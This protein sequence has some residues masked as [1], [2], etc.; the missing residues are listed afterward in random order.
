MKVRL[1]VDRLRL[2][3]FVSELDRPWLGTPFLFQGFLIEEMQD[4][5]QLREVSRYVF[6]D[7]LQSSQAREVQEAI[8]NAMGNVSS[9]SRVQKISVEFEEWKGAAR[10]RATLKKLSQTAQRSNESIAKVL[11]DVRLGNSL[12][13][14]ANR[15]AVAELVTTVQQNPKTAQWMTLLQN[16]DEAIAAHCTNVSV[17]ATGFAK[18]LGWPETM[19]LIIGEGAMLHD[20]GMSRVPRFILDKPGPLSRREFELIKMHGR[21]ASDLLKSS[22]LYDPKVIEIVRWHHE[23]LDGS[24]YPDTLRGQQVPDYV[25]VVGIA[26]VYESMTADKPYEQALPPSVALTRLHKRAGK[27]FASQLIEA[28]IRNIGIYPLASLV[29]LNNGLLGIV[30]SSQEENRLK[31][32][33]LLVKDSKGKMIWPRK[34]VNLAALEQQG[35]GAGWTIHSI[36][37]GEAEKIDVQKILVEEFMLR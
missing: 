15:E 21:Y 37:D 5:K 3:M 17:L 35:I 11:D 29:R 14:G 27:H 34:L 8:R 18:F 4:L 28:F 20:A 19:Q 33:L 2:G 16:T 26:D 30:T 7:D 13:F 36:V 1:D 32:I 23:R 22:G 12:N 25:Q 31:P 9:N 24:G 6:V 10:L